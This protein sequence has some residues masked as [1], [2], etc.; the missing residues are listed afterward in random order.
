MKMLWKS[1]KRGLSAFQFAGQVSEVFFERRCEAIGSVYTRLPARSSRYSGSA[2][3]G[4]LRF[5]SPGR[6]PKCFLNALV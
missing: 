6:Y 5:N 3:A 2:P 4:Y 1:G